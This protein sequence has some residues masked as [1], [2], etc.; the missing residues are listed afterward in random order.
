MK[1]IEI[2]GNARTSIGKASNR[3]LR[4][5]DKVP[6][7]LYGG[8]ENIHFQGHELAF[9]DLIY[10]PNVHTVSLDVDGQKYN[11]VLQAIQFHPLTDKIL[12]IDFLELKEDKPVKIQ[13]PVKM[14]GASEGVKEGG[15]LTLK[16]RKITVKALP[17]DLPDTIEV[18]ITPLAIGDTFRVSEINI[19][20]VEVLDSPNNMVVS[21]RVTRKVIVEETPVVA[22]ATEEGGEAPAEGEEKK[23]EAAKP[24]S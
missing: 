19:P 4:N 22:A 2:S 24:T 21:V 1:S 9:R 6:C 8:S 7:V 18:D 3:E 16:M 13:V 5:S 11:A 12:H 23:E 15:K 14:T 10:T 20:G 17:K